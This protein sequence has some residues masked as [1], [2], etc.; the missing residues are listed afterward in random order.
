MS[1]DDILS[2]LAP[3]VGRLVYQAVE[4]FAAR[5]YERAAL[6]WEEARRKQRAIDLRR[7]KSAAAKK[8]A[9]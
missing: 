3:S 2:V 7:A 5:D 1:P 8:A 9:R 6:L 4:S